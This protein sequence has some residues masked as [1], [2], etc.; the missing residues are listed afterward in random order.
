VLVG[1]KN[2]NKTNRL[3]WHKP[4]LRGHLTNV[5]KIRTVASVREAS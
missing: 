3:G 1:E 2:N 4:K 5:A